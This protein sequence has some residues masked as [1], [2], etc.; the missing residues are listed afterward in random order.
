MNTFIVALKHEAYH[1][2]K[3]YRLVL[4]VHQPFKVYQTKNMRVILSGVGRSS[5]YA[6]TK[7]ALEDRDTHHGLWINFG[8]AGDRTLPIGSLVS[9]SKVTEDTSGRSWY[10]SIKQSSQSHVK[11]L[12]TCNTPISQYPLSSVCDM[13]ASGFMDA[14]SEAISSEHIH[15]LKLISDNS[16]SGLGNLTKVLMKQLVAENIDLIDFYIKSAEQNLSIEPKNLPSDVE[17]I[18]QEQHFTVTQT[19]QLLELYRSFSALCPEE[20]WPSIE[21]NSR[22]K[23]SDI[24]AKLKSQITQL[25]PKL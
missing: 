7:F 10:P 3:K 21:L 19:R 22:D 5:S 9:V 13:E 15:V 4:A 17:K 20:T 2:I 23:A 1:L 16:S 11:E 18:F 8:V 12:L 24:I 6:A 25:S 14:V